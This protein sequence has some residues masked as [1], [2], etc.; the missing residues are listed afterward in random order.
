LKLD[1]LMGGIDGYATPPGLGS[2]AGPLGAL[3]LAAGT[4]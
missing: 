4:I 1:E 2:M 3:A